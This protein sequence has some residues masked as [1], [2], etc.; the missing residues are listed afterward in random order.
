MERQHELLMQQASAIA[1]RFEGAGGGGGG[2]GAAADDE[3]DDEDGQHASDVGYFSA[4][5]AQIQQ[6][7]KKSKPSVAVTA[8]KPGPEIPSYASA[9]IQAAI[10]AGFE[11]GLRQQVPPAPCPECAERRR[12][13]RE[14]ARVSRIARKVKEIESE[15]QRAQTALDLAVAGNRADAVAALQQEVARHAREKSAAADA[16]NQERRAAA[17]LEMYKKAEA[18]QRAAGGP[19]PEEEEEEEEESEAEMPP[20]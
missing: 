4:M 3:D 15:Q 14:A 8:V 13:N 7:A 12:R 2:G 5:P 18:A 17:Q 16:L 11:M 1:N 20:F 6:P 19:P 10:Q 9:S